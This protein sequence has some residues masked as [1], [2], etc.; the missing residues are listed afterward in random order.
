MT[1]IFVSALL[2][3]GLASPGFAADRGNLQL[4]H[5]VSRQVARYAYLTIFDA[6]HANVNAGVVT[7]T[8]K[9]TMPFKSADIEKRVAKVDGVTSVRNQIEVLP[10]SQF[11]NALRVGIARAIYAHPALSIYGIGVDPSIHVIVERGRVTLDGVVNNDAD[12]L[13]ANSIARSSGAFGVKNELKTNEEV[14][15]ELETL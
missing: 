8:G 7:L 10:V 1:S 13:I 11:D 5:N 15:K 14:K 4:F 9:V 12:R 6:V 2:T 3:L